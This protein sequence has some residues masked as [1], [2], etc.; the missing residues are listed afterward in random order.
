MNKRTELS[1]PVLRTGRIKDAMAR[2]SLGRETIR[3]VAK[4]AGAIIRVGKVC[5]YDFERL[6]RY[7]ASLA[8]GSGNDKL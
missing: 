6:D 2:Y 8:G 7:F 4:E 1:N 5:L 3:N